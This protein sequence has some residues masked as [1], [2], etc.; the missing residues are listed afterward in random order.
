MVKYVVLLRRRE[1]VSAEQF[2]E[3]WLTIHRSL[4]EQLPGLR[5]YTLSPTIP[6]SDYPPAFD[7]VGEL[8][9]DSAEAA[10]HAFQSEAGRATRADTPNFAD[11][12]E[13]VRFFA[14]D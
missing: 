6:R 4:V 14:D 13:A 8:W 2:R 7:G 10:L 1:G 12:A 9:F 11:S 3:H 5:G